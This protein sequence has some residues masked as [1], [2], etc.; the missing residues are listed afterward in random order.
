M[1][2]SIEHAPV[3]DERQQDGSGH[4][5][6]VE[7]S[8]TRKGGGKDKQE[9]EK[10]PEASPNE[11]DEGGQDK[12]RSGQDRE[13]VTEQQSQDNGKNGAHQHGLHPPVVQKRP[14]G[15]LANREESQQRHEQEGILARRGGGPRKE[16]HQ[17]DPHHRGLSRAFPVTPPLRR[18]TQ[19]HHEDEEKGRRNHVGREEHSRKSQYGSEKRAV[20]DG[21]LH[22]GPSSLRTHHRE[23]G[24]SK[25]GDR[26]QVSLPHD[27]H[28]IIGGR[29]AQLEP[30]R[31][32]PIG[33]VLLVV[34]VAVVAREGLVANRQL[35]RALEQRGL[36]TLPHDGTNCPDFQADPD[37][38]HERSRKAHL[39]GT[40]HS[41]SGAMGLSTAKYWSFLP[42]IAFT[43]G[44]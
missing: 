15:V 34:V 38:G 28:G 11:S 23:Q 8:S 22:P 44:G 43:T 19:H 20:E 4:E 16:A 41:D 13:T 29:T 30:R 9:K 37:H 7:R 31:R 5:T 24:K 27:G 42:K 2:R 36:V 33:E 32:H 12:E 3:E 26:Q 18:G 6:A 40:R 35:H 1:A 39:S 21:D 17:E 25:E 10:G 14:Q